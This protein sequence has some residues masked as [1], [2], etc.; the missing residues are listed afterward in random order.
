MP[1]FCHILLSSLLSS[2]LKL[3]DNRRTILIF[4]FTIFSSNVIIVVFVTPYVISN[5][6]ILFLSSLLKSTINSNSL[7]YKQLHDTIQ[8]YSKIQA[9]LIYH[10]V[11]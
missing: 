6:M 11:G 9:V 2:F 8:V 1:Y 3:G 4:N 5:Y 10:F 7:Y